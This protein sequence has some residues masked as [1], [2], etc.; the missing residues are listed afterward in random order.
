MRPI[1]LKHYVPKRYVPD[2][3][4]SCD[5]CGKQFSRPEDNCYLWRNEMTRS[6]LN[7]L[8]DL[9][10]REFH[11]YERYKPDA[12]WFV[13]HCDFCR[14]RLEPGET[15]Y[16]DGI[17][18]FCSQDCVAGYVQRQGFLDA[19]DLRRRLDPMDHRKYAIEAYKSD[20]GAVESI[21]SWASRTFGSFDSFAIKRA[22]RGYRILMG[23]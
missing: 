6:C 18:E 7:C 11:V 21:Q 13:S 12:P 10:E 22:V 3:W 2:M 20:Y 16:G 5:H 14:N 8:I 9:N 19:I 4:F 17:A 23:L 15:T 1:S